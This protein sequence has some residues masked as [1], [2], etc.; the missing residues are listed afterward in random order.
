MER[1]GLGNKRCKTLNPPPSLPFVLAPLVLISHSCA[2]PTNNH[3][4][5]L[6]LFAFL[7]PLAVWSYNRYR[8]P[9]VQ[10]DLNK[11]YD[12]RPSTKNPYGQSGAN[13]PY[14]GHGGDKDRDELYKNKSS[15]KID[16]RRLFSREYD[17]PET[18]S[19]TE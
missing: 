14:Y 19:L 16:S 10:E 7:S 8:D 1:Q 2:P 15:R 9:D 13:N 4:L 11:L 5:I 18:F 6:K 3:S 12:T 17:F